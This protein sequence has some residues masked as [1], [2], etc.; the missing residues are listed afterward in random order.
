M[1]RALHGAT[2]GRR[3]EL[4]HGQR[5]LSKR[6]S[7]AR[8]GIPANLNRRVPGTPQSV[9]PGAGKALRIRRRRL[10]SGSVP[11]TCRSVGVRRLGWLPRR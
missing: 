3:E 5:H 8:A 7:G 1:P 10:V 11:H 9:G 4:M 2:S 6:E